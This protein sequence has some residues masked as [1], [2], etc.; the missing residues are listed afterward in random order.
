MQDILQDIFANSHGP[1][2]RVASSGDDQVQPL[3]GAGIPLAEPA[4]LCSDPQ[5]LRH[6]SSIVNWLWLLESSSL[7]WTK[8]FL[9]AVA[10]PLALI[11]PFEAPYKN[12]FLLPLDS[13][14]SHLDIQRGIE[15]WVFSSSV[16][17]S[18]FIPSP[19]KDTAV[20]MDPNQPRGPWQ[21]HFTVCL[22][23]SVA[24]CPV[25]LPLGAS[26]KFAIRPSDGLYTGPLGNCILVSERPGAL[27]KSMSQTRGWRWIAL[28]E[29]FF[30]LELRSLINSIISKV[31]Y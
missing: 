29:S 12:P 16:R 6:S 26:L 31:L 22:C 19:E 1:S 3:S 11:L 30:S 9:Q 17:M 10:A 14:L 2:N 28:G 24:G 7:C 25:R 15:S 5:S 13:H 18:Q 23:I 21:P 27:W 4:S 8:L 20:Q